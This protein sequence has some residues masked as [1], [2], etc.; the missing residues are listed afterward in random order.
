MRTNTTTTPTY[1]QL[2]APGVVEREVQPEMPLECPVCGS[3]LAIS[4]IVINTVI[5]CCDR[6]GPVFETEVKR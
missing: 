2:S 1:F 4:T 5:L 3:D 6:C